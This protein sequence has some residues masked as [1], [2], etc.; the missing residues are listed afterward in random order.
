MRVQHIH[1]TRSSVGFAAECLGQHQGDAQTAN[2]GD[3]NGQR[4]LKFRS[5]FRWWADDDL[6]YTV[7][8]TSELRWDYGDPAFGTCTETA[9]G[10][11]H[12]RFW[13]Q[14]GP[15][16]NT[17]AIFMALSYEEPSSEEHDIIENG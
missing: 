9:E 16:A 8:E 11:N 10:G 13:I 15:K 1:D 7:N 17:G 3:G 14:N 4:T 12:F 5:V 6:S 2:L